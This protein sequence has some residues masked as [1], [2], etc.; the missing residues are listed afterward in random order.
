MDDGMMD[1]GWWIMDYGLWIMD[2]DES[3]IF[4]KWYPFVHSREKQNLTMK[5]SHSNPFMFS[6]I[7]RICFVLKW[8][9]RSWIEKKC[10]EIDTFTAFPKPF[11][12][13]WSKPLQ[14]LYVF[15]PSALAWLLLHLRRDFMMS[16]TS[17]KKKTK[18]S[19]LARLCQRK[20][21]F[22]WRLFL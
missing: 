12:L 11:L 1:D 2:A 14:V 21:M 20:N 22:L 4:Y 15:V 3:P 6:Y 8:I 16:L 17:N 18:Q 5:K 10:V 19:C 13:Q 7:I 9:S